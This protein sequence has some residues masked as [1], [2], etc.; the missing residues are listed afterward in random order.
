[1]SDFIKVDSAQLR[2]TA[3]N[4]SHKIGVISSEFDNIMTTVSGSA[5]YWQGDAAEAYRRKII[6]KQDKAAC[7]LRR[8]EEYI[9]DLG[10]MSTVYE[11]AEVR[12]KQISA[13]LDTDVIY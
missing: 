11:T 10:S 1:M 3:E 4:V 6:T 5:S 12:S 7:F 8:L 9:D 13:D 2:H